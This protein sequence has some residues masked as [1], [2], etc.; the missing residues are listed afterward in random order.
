MDERKSE[1]LREEEAKKDKEKATQRESKERERENRRGNE[2]KKQTEEERG[3]GV[4][5]KEDRGVCFSQSRIKERKLYLIPNTTTF[6][7][8]PADTQ[9]VAVVLETLISINGTKAMRVWKRLLI[10]K[11]GL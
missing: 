5:R 7:P 8:P 10:S 2:E 4:T 1:I 3:R 11:R 6:G 9:Y